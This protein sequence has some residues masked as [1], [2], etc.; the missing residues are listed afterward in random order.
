MQSALHMP[1]PF[2]SQL[3]ELSGKLQHCHFACSFFA[4]KLRDVY[5]CMN[6]PLDNF[7]HAKL[8]AGG[9]TV[10]GRRTR[11]YDKDFIF[12]PWCQD[13][14]WTLF[15]VVRP[16]LQAS[17][18]LQQQIG[19]QSVAV[20]ANGANTTET[21]ARCTGILHL[22]S[23]SSTAAQK[24]TSEKLRRQATTLLKAYLNE[25]YWKGKEG[26]REL[27]RVDCFANMPEIPVRAV[28]QPNYD[29]CALYMLMNIR[30]FAEQGLLLKPS[31]ESAEEGVGDWSR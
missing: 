23:L 6:A 13:D 9:E 2:L 10:L 7:D 16:G 28:Q 24:R 12:I 29:D 19:F 21:D 26:D 30:K 3:H 11:I 5:K 1:V 8:H 17:R 31:L 15:V 4:R 18:T 20:E 14:H 22:D 25:G 27:P